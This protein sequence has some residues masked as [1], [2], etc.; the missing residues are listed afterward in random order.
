MVVYL[1]CEYL[2][3]KHFTHV[4]LTKNLIIHIFLPKFTPKIFSLFKNTTYSIRQA[5]FS[6]FYFALQIRIHKFNG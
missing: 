1:S 2:N 5:I 3:S 6:P 4:F